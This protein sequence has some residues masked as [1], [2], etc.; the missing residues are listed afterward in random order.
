MI[1]E[2][3][4]LNV[5][6]GRESEFEQAFAEAQKIISS[7]AGYQWHRLMKCHEVEGRYLLLVQWAKLEDHT[8]GF[9]MSPHY[10]QW[11]KILH[12]FYNPFPEVEHYSTV[13]PASSSSGF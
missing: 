3:A 8:V 11:K 10:G 6:A 4:V 7:I 12:H 5:V 2:H 1:L 9:R 13:V